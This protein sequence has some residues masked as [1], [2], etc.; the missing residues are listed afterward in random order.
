[1]RSQT[2]PATILVVDDQV[3]NR[4]LVEALLRPEGYAIR[5]AGGGREALALVASGDID[6]ILL[7]IMM[8]DVDGIEIARRLK[9]DPSTAAIPIIMVTSLDDRASRLAALGVGAEEFLTKPVDRA[10]LWVRV[11]NLLRLKEYSDFLADHNQILEQQVQQRTAQL[12]ESHLETIFTMTRAAEYKD[13]ETGAHIQRVSHYAVELG[14]CVGLAADFVD[15]L[16]YAMPMHDIGKIGIP[17]HILLKPGPL[18]ADEWAI[19][20]SHTTFGAQILETSKSPYCTMGA[21]IA[22]CHHE[23]WDG[24]GYPSGLRGEEIPL[25]AR[26]MSVCDVYDALRSKRP[27]KP[28]FS[29]AKAVSIMLGGDG[30]T[31]PEHFDPALLAAFGQRAAAFED[32]FERHDD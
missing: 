10:E 28:A 23:R 2:T 9:A 13:E 27:Y 15:T 11:R 16:F 3:S 20:K 14:Q 32:I 30:R 4:K 12:R 22:R 31:R 6:L 26:I 17:D 1:M 19:M 7:D 21:D 5:S 25:A 24:S 29:H 18:S 8:P